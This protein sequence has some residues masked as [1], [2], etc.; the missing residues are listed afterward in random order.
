MTEMEY[1]KDLLPCRR[2]DLETRFGCNERSARGQIYRARECGIAILMP[3]RDCDEYRIAQT[4]DEVMRCYREMR[5]RALRSLVAAE[6]MIRRYHP[7]EQT[8]I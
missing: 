3:D 1:I 2:R 7:D 8:R 6:R 4:E 5:G